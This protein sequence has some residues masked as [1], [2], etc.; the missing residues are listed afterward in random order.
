MSGGLVNSVCNSQLNWSTLRTLDWI[1]E[2]TPQ[3]KQSS[4]LYAPRFRQNTASV[5]IY[6]NSD[7]VCDILIRKVSLQ[8]LWSAVIGQYNDAR[9]EVS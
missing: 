6:L 7:Q 4:L 3:I 2:M 8:A 1:I 5:D 9:M